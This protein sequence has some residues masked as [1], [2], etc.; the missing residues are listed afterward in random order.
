MSSTPPLKYNNVICKL[1]NP[2]EFVIIYIYILNLQLTISPAVPPLGAEA[3]VFK[4]Q[5]KHLRTKVILG[6]STIVMADAPEVLPLPHGV[7]TITINIDLTR[8]K[9]YKPS[10]G[11]VGDL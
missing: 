5:Q 4:N 8:P 9:M 3:V 11:M 7:G 6:Y 1:L 10:L 2:F